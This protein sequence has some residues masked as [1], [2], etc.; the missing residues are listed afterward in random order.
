M[1]SYENKINLRFIFLCQWNKIL[2]YSARFYYHIRDCRRLR[3]YVKVREL[4]VRSIR[5]IYYARKSRKTISMNDY[6]ISC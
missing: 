6:S 4:Q 2:R 3:E 5:I 1:I